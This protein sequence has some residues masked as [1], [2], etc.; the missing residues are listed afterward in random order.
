MPP[1]GKKCK[2]LNVQ[3]DNDFVNNDMTDA[4]TVNDSVSKLSKSKKKKSAA[5]L[6]DNDFSSDVG[7]ENSKH[8]KSGKKT[9]LLRRQIQF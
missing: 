2:R 1:T 7:S 4:S 8:S 5:V 6:S 3:S 9:A